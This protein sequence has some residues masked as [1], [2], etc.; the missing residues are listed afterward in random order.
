MSGAQRTPPLRANSEA[1]GEGKGKD[2]QDGRTDTSDVRRLVSPTS[3][4]TTGRW[5]KL[6]LPKTADHIFTHQLSSDA[7]EV[8]SAENEAP[9]EPGSHTTT[10]V[11]LPTPKEGERYRPTAGD[12]TSDADPSRGAH[13]V[14]VSV[15]VDGDAQDVVPLGLER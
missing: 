8:Q 6:K 5:R 1:T 15:R 12:R 4:Q 7:S 10:P 3:R 13:A 2:T 14:E 11:P 9:S